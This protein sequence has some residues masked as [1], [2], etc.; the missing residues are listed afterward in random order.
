MH[1][2]CI[3][4]LKTIYICKVSDNEKEIKEH[5]DA[6]DKLNKTYGAPFITAALI[7]DHMNAIEQLKLRDKK[8]ADGK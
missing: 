8:D 2:Y 1:Q 6:I 5:Q 3:G 7:R 4:N